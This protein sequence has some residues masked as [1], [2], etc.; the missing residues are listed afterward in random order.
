M[1]QAI[2]RRIAAGEQPAFAELVDMYQRQLFGFL[3]RLGM[4]QAQAEDIAQETFLRAWT[5]L[6]SYQPE[7][8]Q[9]ATWLFTIARNLAYNALQKEPCQHEMLDAVIP[10]PA[11]E[12]PDPAQIMERTRQHSRLHSA[13]RQLPM[14]DRSALALVY[15]HELR[16]AD[17]ARIENDS[18]AAIKTRLHR[19]KQRLRAIL[20]SDNESETFYEK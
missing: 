1:V 12:Q 20:Q 13:L 4:S 9:F 7:R 16:L 17:V 3:G 8:A 5:H 14:S 19:A 15:V 18:L 6:H 2:L 11:S 10:E